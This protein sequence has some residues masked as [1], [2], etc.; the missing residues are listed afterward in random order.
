MHPCW[1]NLNIKI[2]MENME[3][4]FFLKVHKWYIHLFDKGLNISQNKYPFM[5]TLY[6]KN[7]FC[8]GVWLKAVLNCS[9]RW[10]TSHLG[11]QRA[12]AP[13]I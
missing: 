6:M 5:C 11:V 4:I 2:Y 13:T 10:Y 7:M 9:Q 12:R 8:K 1:I 3:I